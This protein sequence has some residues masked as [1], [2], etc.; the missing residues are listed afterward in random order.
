MEIYG[1]LCRDD[2]WSSASKFINIL[3]A[4]VQCTPLQNK[5]SK[6]TWGD[7]FFWVISLN[8]PD[9]HYGLSPQ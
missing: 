4:G 8:E 2:H 7:L 5:Y 6:N 1:K 9:G 3:K